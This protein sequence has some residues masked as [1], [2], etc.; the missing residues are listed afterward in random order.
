MHTSIRELHDDFSLALEEYEP[1]A[2]VTAEFPSAGLLLEEYG[3]AVP[4]FAIARGHFAE[5]II[6]MTV[7]GLNAGDVYSS[8]KKYSQNF[9]VADTLRYSS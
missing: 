2:D 8:R 4:P 1:G 6:D 9:L 3:D 5:E 7:Q